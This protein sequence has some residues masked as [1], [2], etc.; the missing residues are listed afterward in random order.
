[1]RNYPLQFSE[2]ISVSSYEQGLEQIISSSV[3]QS[4]A[5][6]LEMQGLNKPAEQSFNSDTESHEKFIQAAEA[7]Q[8]ATLE[9]LLV[10][11]IKKTI[12]AAYGSLLLTSVEFQETAAGTHAVVSRRKMTI[13]Q[14]YLTALTK[15][16]LYS[17]IQAIYN[18]YNGSK[19]TEVF[20]NKCQEMDSNRGLKS[21][22]NNATSK[23][24]DKFVSIIVHELVHVIQNSKQPHRGGELEYRSYLD[25]KDKNLVSVAQKRNQALLTGTSTPELDSEYFKLYFSSPQE[26]A[27]HAHEAALSVIKSQNLTSVGQRFD[28]AAIVSAI[29][30]IT[31]SFV[32][33]PTTPKERSIRN[34]YMKLVYQEIERYIRSRY[35]QANPTHK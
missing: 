28:P 32:S 27:A 25:R 3:L 26:I 2:A 23:V 10:A 29:D 35:Q 24:I 16:A 30:Q 7:Y 21:V 5:G 22:V 8:S 9:E 14:R 1:M 34:R 12:N 13:S 4:F 11:G 18:G 31:S 6:I 15:H 19:R 17:L 33:A 20:Y